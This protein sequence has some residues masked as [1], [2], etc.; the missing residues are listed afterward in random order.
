MIETVRA[1]QSFANAMK[2][3]DDSH[4]QLINGILKA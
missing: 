4:S 3:L 1:Y 2:S